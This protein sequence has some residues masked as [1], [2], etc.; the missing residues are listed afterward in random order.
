[1]KTTLTYD[2]DAYLVVAR[3]LKPAELGRL[4]QALAATMN[5]LDG[6]EHVTGSAI[7]LAYNLLA[8]SIEQSIERRAA[9][10]SNGSKGGRPRRSGT[11]APGGDTAAGADDCRCRDNEVKPKAEVKKS[12]KEDLP[13]TPPIEEKIKKNNSQTN[14]LS[15]ARAS[16]VQVPDYDEL[17]RMML[18]EEPWL[19]QLCMARRIGHDDMAT[20]VADFV[21]YLRQQDSRETLS[22]AKT[23]FVNQLPYI[24]KL[25]KNQ[26]HHA[27]TTHT[28]NAWRQPA[29]A[30]IQH[31][32]YDPV[33]RAEAEHASRQA[34]V[35]RQIAALA[36]EARHPRPLPF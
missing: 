24:I 26:Q 20:Y 19:E 4:F 35:A 9:L 1:M 6:S 29:N 2:T 11:P 8:P 3:S 28:R 36:D 18:S 31:Y 32:I 13:P 27:D 21:N 17:E 34:A 15:P 23:H 16:G 25:Y 12:K 7:R 30:C 22:Q 10:R 5:G 33:A 14:S